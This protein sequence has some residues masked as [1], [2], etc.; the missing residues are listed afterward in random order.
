MNSPVESSPRQARRSFRWLVAS[1]AALLVL[2][3]ASC[4]SW[5]RKMIYFPPVFD[6]ATLDELGARA[7]LER[8]KN[9]AGQTIGWKRLSPISPSQGQVLVLHGNGGCAV[10]CSHYADAIQQVAAL[11]VFIPEYPGYAD[12][13]GKPTERS[14][15]TAADEAFKQLS[16]DKPIYL[17]GESLG[18]GV[19]AYLA[20]KYP[21]RVAGVALLAPY[22]SLT[23]VAADH[24]RILPVRLILCDRFPAEDYLKSYRGPV[25]MLVGSEDKVVPPKFG[26]KL[27]HDYAGPKQLRE[28]PNGDHGSVMTQP[29]GIW[30]EIIEFWRSHSSLGGKWSDSP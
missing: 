22:D 6:S 28:I 8:W 23:A 30:K 19:A 26:L 18:T 24:V 15:Y 11:D 27:Y 20:G 10:W 21:D 14:L 12:R 1:G 29:P 4:A 5:Q 13:P 2:V 16:A 7:K 3:C 9:P 17:L 25:A